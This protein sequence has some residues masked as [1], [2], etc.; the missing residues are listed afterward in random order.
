M[1]Q[2]IHS[3]H[4]IAI[5]IC[6]NIGQFLVECGEVSIG[7]VSF[8][9]GLHTTQLSQHFFNIFHMLQRL[10]HL[11][12]LDTLCNV[13]HTLSLWSH[14]SH[15]VTFSTLRHICHLLSQIA[16]YQQTNGNVS[17]SIQTLFS[18]RVDLKGHQSWPV[19]PQPASPHLSQKNCFGLGPML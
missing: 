16:A 12:T 17:M 15:T 8:Y 13:C 19:C 5:I 14:L 6:N 3:L 2:Y 18:T 4:I 11:Y 10:S 7:V 9:L 1:F